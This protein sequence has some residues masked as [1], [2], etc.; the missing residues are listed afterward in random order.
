[1]SPSLS[2]SIASTCAGA[3]TPAIVCLGE[4]SARRLA[5][6]AHDV[7]ERVAH[8][9][10]VEPVAIEIADRH[11][12]DLRPLLARGE[13]PIALAVKRDAVEPPD[14]QERSLWPVKA[15][16]IPASGDRETATAGGAGCPRRT[17]S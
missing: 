2:K 17:Q 8:E 16:A 11:M 12:R 3:A 15:R 10:V 7:A 13:L 1:M 4:R 6:P 5:D 14:S 9:D